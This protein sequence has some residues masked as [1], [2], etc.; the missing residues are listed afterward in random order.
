MPIENAN[1]NITDLALLRGYGVFDFFKAIDGRPI[2]MED[3]LDRFESS[4]WLLGLKI[5]YTRDE[6]KKNILEL[7]KLNKHKLLG[8][9]LVCTGGYSIDGYAPAEK[10]NLFMVAKPFIMHPFEKELSLITVEHQ[11]ELAEIKSINYIKPISVLA[12]LRISE[13]DDVLYYSDGYITESSRSNIFIVKNG[14]LVTPDTGIL[15]GIT[16]KKIL[17]FAS[18]I[19]PIEIRPVKLEEV[20][21]ADEVFMTGSTKR[22][23]PITKIDNKSFQTGHFTRTLY[24]RLLVEENLS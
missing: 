15:K 20:L 18:E 19:L 10:P 8:I 7:V 4:T 17:Q 11:R 22:I 5:P 14:L 23:T 24:N 13:A 21:E 12:Q 6:L 16:R 1:L 3:H 9:K 2:F